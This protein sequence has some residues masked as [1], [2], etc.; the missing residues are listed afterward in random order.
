MDEWPARRKWRT[1]EAFA[2]A[3]AVEGAGDGE[4]ALHGGGL[5][6]TVAEYAN[7][8][9]DARHDDLPLYIFD[10]WVLGFGGWVGVGGCWGW[11]G[12]VGDWGLVGGWL[13]MWD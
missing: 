11:L 3:A 7:Y 5:S 8:A 6:F 2:E 13:G 4:M 10:R 12:M 9:R 1:P